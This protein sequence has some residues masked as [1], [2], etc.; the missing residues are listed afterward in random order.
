MAVLSREALI[1]LTHY[2]GSLEI[3]EQ[4]KVAI[5]LSVFCGGK[6]QGIHHSGSVGRRMKWRVEG[7]YGG[8]S[9]HVQLKDF[10]GADA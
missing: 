6:N 4:T 10:D 9:H 5:S 1:Y 8:R 3:V 2:S 7:R